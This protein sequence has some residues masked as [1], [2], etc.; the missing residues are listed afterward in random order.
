LAEARQ[1]PR[2][3]FRRLEGA[4]GGMA[5]FMVFMLSELIP[6]SCPSVQLLSKGA[7]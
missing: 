2:R 1:L 6:P 3:G 4:S 5:C 7:R